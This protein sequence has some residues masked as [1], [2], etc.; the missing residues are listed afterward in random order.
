MKRLLATLAGSCL[1]GLSLNGLAAEDKPLW[2]LGMGA[3]GL[4]F[5]VYRGSDQRR[6]FLMPVPYFVY[7]GDFFKADRRGVRGELID[8]ERFELN[9]SGSASLPVGSGEVDARRG[10]PGLKAT[11]GLGPSVE[12]VLWNSGDSRKQLRFALPVRGAFTLEGNPEFVG[13]QITPRLNLDIAHPAGFDGWRLGLLAGPVYGSR[14]EHEYFYSVA[15]TYATAS[16]PAYQAQGGYA[17]MQALASLS[18]RFP[19]FWLGGFVRYDTLKG[20][21]FDDSPLV[22]KSHYFAAGFGIAWI[23]GESSRRVSSED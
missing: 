19:G 15:P 1:L 23:I 20:A 6:D 8:S 16:R 18:K 9:L 10:M 21:V 14:E 12:A 3:G 2:E 11:V 13:W 7:R 5:P 22:R 4:S 17:G